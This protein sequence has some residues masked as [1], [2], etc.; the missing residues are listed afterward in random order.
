MIHAHEMAVDEIKQACVTEDDE[1]VQRLLDEEESNRQRPG[2]LKALRTRLGDADVS[3]KSPKS[4]LQTYPEIE[5]DAED[6]AKISTNVN[7]AVDDAGI[8]EFPSTSATKTSGNH[9]EDAGPISLDSKVDTTLPMYVE[10][11]ANVPYVIDWR[12][13]KVQAGQVHFY[14]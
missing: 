14:D 13:Y 9:E 10:G 7:F 1:T 8:S 6:A 3:P 4:N 5:S 2:A 11:P 12:G